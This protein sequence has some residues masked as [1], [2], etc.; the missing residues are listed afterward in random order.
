MYNIFG[1]R[2]IFG[3]KNVDNGEVWVGS[4]RNAIHLVCNRRVRLKDA[5]LILAKRGHKSKSVMC[6]VQ[7]AVQDRVDHEVTVLKEFVNI[8]ALK[9][10]RERRR[11][12]DDQIQIYVS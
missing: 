7:N 11:E 4:K 10:K 6:V 12:S 9:S 3:I 1:K 5:K 8:F 2:I